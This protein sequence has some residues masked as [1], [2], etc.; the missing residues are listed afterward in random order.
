MGFISGLSVEN[1]QSNYDSLSLMDRSLS[2]NERDDTI[3]PVFGYHP[4]LKCIVSTC[5]YS[6]EKRPRANEW[7]QIMI[8][9]LPVLASLKAASEAKWAASMAS[10]LRPVILLSLEAPTTTV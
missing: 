6:C 4:R 9:S 7:I 3:W 10:A 8:T 5:S 1:D 2:R